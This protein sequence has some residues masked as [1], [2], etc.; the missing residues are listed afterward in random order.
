MPARSTLVRECA[1]EYAAATDVIGSAAATTGIPR[2]ELRRQLARSGERIAGLLN[3]S[4]SPIAI[5]ESGVRVSGIAGLVRVTPSFELELVPKFLDPRQGG[6]REDFFYLAT[7]SRHGRLLPTE[8]LRSSTQSATDLATLVARAMIGMYWANHRR[9]LR[10][11]SRHKFDDFAIDDDVEPESILLPEPEGFSQQ[12]IRYS[13]HNQFN[14]AISA[15]SRA[16]LPEVSDPQT[17]RQLARLCEILAPQAREQEVRHRRVPSR[18]RRWQSL[19]DLALEVLD[20]FGLS[21]ASGRMRAPGYVLSTWQVWEDFVTLAVRLGLG[22]RSVSA[23]TAASLGDRAISVAPGVLKQSTVWVTPDITFRADVTGP[24]V[25]IDA[26]YKT[27]RD[28]PRTRITEADLYEALAFASAARAS[29]VLLVYPAVPSV[30]SGPGSL[31]AC[32]LFE[33]VEANGVVVAALAVETCGVSRVGGL[34]LFAAGL[35][36]GIRA[37]LA[38][39]S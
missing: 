20:G 12:A 9:P 17:S 34:R 29:R 19:Y 14:A 1:V 27:R 39:M 22:T 25:L 7:L 24:P 5:D 16:L 2:E 10:T 13:R 28:A 33:R 21:Y 18:A 26:K 3:L 15:A 8:N 35:A 4:E 36:S 37:A 32:T 6:W 30:M 11:Y 23:K 31:G 38:D